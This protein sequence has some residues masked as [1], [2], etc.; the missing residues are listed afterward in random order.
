MAI[1]AGIGTTTYVLVTPEGRWVGNGHV[2]YAGGDVS[3]MAVLHGEGAH[4]GLTATVLIRSEPDSPSTFEGVILPGEVPTA[5]Q[6]VAPDPLP[7]PATG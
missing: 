2:F 5:P 3:E 1:V 7:S 4:E 6:P